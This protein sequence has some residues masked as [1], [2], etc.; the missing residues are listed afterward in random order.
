MMLSNSKF[1][2]NDNARMDER[3]K[4]SVNSERTASDQNTMLCLHLKEE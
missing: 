4:A 2:L 1:A 3:T